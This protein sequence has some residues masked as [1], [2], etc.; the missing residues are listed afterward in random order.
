MKQI[1]TESQTSFSFSSTSSSPS[2][3]SSSS[4]NSLL[5]FMNRYNLRSSPRRPVTDHETE[6]LNSRRPPPYQIPQRPLASRS[7]IPSLREINVNSSSIPQLYSR[8]SSVNDV[9]GI[10]VDVSVTV[11]SVPSVQESASAQDYISDLP[12]SSSLSPSQP[13]GAESRLTSTVSYDC[14]I[15]MEVIAV[16]DIEYLPCFHY[17]HKHC[18]QRASVRSRNCPVCRHPLDGESQLQSDNTFI[19][20]TSSNTPNNTNVQRIGITSTTEQQSLDT[21]S[22]S[23][24]QLSQQQISNRSIVESSATN[25][26]TSRHTMSIAPHSTASQSSSTQRNPTNTSR[27]DRNRSNAPRNLLPNNS[28]YRGN[29]YTDEMISHLLDYVDRYLPLNVRGWE[30]VAEELNR[31]YTNIIRDADSVKK[32]FQKIYLT[33]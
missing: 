4:N 3:V 2:S 19:D 13:S 30:L 9:N 21:S 15:C 33:K 25:A 20:L 1:P 31:V 10:E 27:R 12:D 22:L 28:R 23:L 18:I 11:P 8:S 17:F 24:T 5:S 16:T 29:N 32:K 14:S 6:S 26:D 7:R